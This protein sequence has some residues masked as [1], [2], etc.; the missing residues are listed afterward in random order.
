MKSKTSRCEYSKNREN[1]VCRTH[2]AYK[3]KQ[4]ELKELK[5]QQAI[6]QLREAAGRINWDR[7]CWPLGGPNKNTSTDR[8]YPLKYENKRTNER[9]KKKGTHD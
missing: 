3:N 5:E 8:A 2:D 4:K 1:R 9:M 7:A 6:F